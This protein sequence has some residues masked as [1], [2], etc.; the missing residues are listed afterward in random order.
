MITTTKAIVL[1]AL[2]YGDSRLIVDLLTE[3]FGRLSFIQHIPKTGRARVKKQFFQPLTIMEAT[4]DFRPNAPLQRLRDVALSAPFISIPFD[5]VKLS[6]ALFIAEFIYYGTRDEQGNEPLF[7]YVT[8]SVRWLDGCCGAVANFHLT[9]MLHI[10]RFIGFSPNTDCD[11]PDACFD[12]R[13]GCF[14]DSVPLHADFLRPEDASRLR[15]LLRMDFSNM[16]LFRMSRE[17]RNRC[18]EIMLN[19][20]RLHVADFPELR[21]FSVMKELFG[22]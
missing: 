1:R 9:F 15:Q 20:Y 11:S 14:T 19:Y 5:P 4:F 10:A 22:S 2:K 17:E 7:E 21:S 8:A 13:S 12:L 18:T 3:Q 16:H 6:I